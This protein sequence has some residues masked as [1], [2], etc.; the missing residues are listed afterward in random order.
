MQIQKNKAEE[1]C[2]KLTGN[3]IDGEKK[4]YMQRQK[5]GQVSARADGAAA[6]RRLLVCRP[7][8]GLCSTCLLD[9][10]IGAHR[11]RRQWMPELM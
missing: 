6:E 5:Q 1:I 11:E 4:A 3:I 10:S 7:G 8:R 9:Q 2:S